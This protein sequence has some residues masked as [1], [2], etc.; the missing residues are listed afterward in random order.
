VQSP[1]L[2]PSQSKDYEN[3][4][5]ERYPNPANLLPIPVDACIFLHNA[6]NSALTWIGRG[7]SDESG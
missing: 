5:V 1:P 3:L 4:P 6:P 7:K 2:C